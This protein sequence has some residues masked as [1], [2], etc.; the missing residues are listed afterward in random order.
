MPINATLSN[1]GQINAG[2][3]SPSNDSYECEEA[4]FD[5]ED[6]QNE[7]NKDFKL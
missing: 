3:S 6:L 2:D 1:E 7:H 4:E 5:R